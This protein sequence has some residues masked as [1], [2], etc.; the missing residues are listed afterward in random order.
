MDTS[1]RKTKIICTAG[2]AIH[3]YEMLKDLCA[4]G[5]NILRI[6]MSHA[7]HAFASESIEWIRRIN[8]ELPFPVAIMIDTQGPE[9]R[10]GTLQTNVKLKKGQEVAVTVRSDENVEH[11]SI[12]V[13]YDKIVDTV[14]IGNRITVDNGLINLEVLE[15]NGG[16]LLCRVLDDGLLGSKRHVNLPGLK[17]DLPSITD[18]DIEDIHFAMEQDVDYIALSFVRSAQDIDDARSLLKKTDSNIKIIAKIEDAEACV[19]RL[20]IIQATDAV[21]IARGDLGV[22]TNAAELPQ[23]Q[24]SIVEDCAK[25]GCRV[26]V[27]THLLESMINCPV[28]TRAEVSDVA[29]AIYEGVDAVMLSGETSIGQYPLR[30]VDQ[31]ISIAHCIEREEGVAF[32]RSLFCNTDKQSLAMSAVHL[33]ESIKADGIVVF[34]HRGIMADLV[35][36]C[37]PRTAPIFAITHDS[38]VQ[39]RLA[40]NRYVWSFCVHFT[41]SD[42]EMTLE[43]GLDALL[44][45]SILSAGTKVVVIS[46]VFVEGK[47]IDSIQIRTIE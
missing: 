28:P 17:V 2:P 10:T 29:N 18:K 44:E 42:P 27:A 35:T 5:M 6:N 7:T 23:M 13:T 21:M 25:Q 30:C 11:T 9:I 22:E 14:Q 8:K 31:L 15:K 34:T 26:I 36:N 37:H 43:T 46:D 39:A 3:S 12:Q 41:P 33:A 16:R 1:Y 45:R 24:R 47:C 4:A 38:K 20:E 19:N 32:Y 40:L